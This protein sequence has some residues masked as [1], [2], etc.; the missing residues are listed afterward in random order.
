[1]TNYAP[2][3]SE[4]DNVYYRRRLTPSDGEPDGRVRPTRDTE[5][6]EIACVDVIR[7]DDQKSTQRQLGEKGEAG[8]HTDSLGRR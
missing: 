6:G 2:N 3:L 5:G 7:N 1:M 4:R 8:R